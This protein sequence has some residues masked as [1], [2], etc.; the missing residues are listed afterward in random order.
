MTQPGAATQRAD[1]RR[2][3]VAVLDAAAELLATRGLAIQVEDVASAA[4]VG[5]ATIYRHYGSREALIREV[6]ATG[7]YT[8][9]AAI[10]T[11]AGDAAPSDALK[12][13]IRTTVDHLAAHRGLVDAAIQFRKGLIDPDPAYLELVST[14]EALLRDAQE[15]GAAR[16]EVTIDDLNALLIGAGVLTTDDSSRGRVCE[17][18]I[19]G[20]SR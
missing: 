17:L 11:G 8:L 14:I 3:R 16:P 2:N 1:A 9:I 13:A 15:I 18:I 5:V 19:R 7:T 4:G 6:L 20:V 12:R 10:R